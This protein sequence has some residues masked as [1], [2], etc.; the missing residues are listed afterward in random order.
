MRAVARL[1]LLVAAMAAL[2]GQSSAQSTRPEGSDR[3]ASSD[4]RPARPG[5]DF[6]VLSLSWSPSY[7]EAEGRR[8]DPRQ[9]RG[10]PRGFV[11][12]GLWPQ[13]ERGFPQFCRSDRERVSRETIRS[14]ADIM[15]SDG[16]IGH[17]WRKHGSCSGLDQDAYFGKVRAARARVVIPPAFRDPL[18]RRSVAPLALETAFIRVNPGLGRESISVVCD[19]RLIREVR[20]C[21][22]PSL[23]FRPCPEVDRRGCRGGDRVLPAA[24]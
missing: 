21:M 2:A 14:L 3:R 18:Q 6:Y 9:C 23:G 13:Y 16:L 24:R 19:G 5:F 11:V 7:C 15:P 8:A 12:H 10:R 4:E 1:V 22:D 20:V 17:Q